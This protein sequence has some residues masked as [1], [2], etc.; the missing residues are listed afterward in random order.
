M[1]VVVFGSGGHAKVAMEILQITGY[2]VVGFLD[3]DLNRHGD[4]IKDL[5][6]VGGREQLDSLKDAG[7]TGVFIGIGNNKVRKD[8]ADYLKDEPFECV[9]AIHPKANIYDSAKLGKG[10]F[11]APGVVVGVDSV[12]NDYSIINSGATIGHDTVVCHGADICPG[13][14][15]AGNVTVGEYTQVGIGSRVIQGLSLGENSIIGAG[16][17]VVRDIPSNV[18][19]FGNPARVTRELDNAEHS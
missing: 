2:E 14:N 9:N 8:I 5:P 19:A 12:I 17:I 16:S 18:V 11:I 7:V 6:V 3:D 15:I 10:L 4:I 13:V 1:K